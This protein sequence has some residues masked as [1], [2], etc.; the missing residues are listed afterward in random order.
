MNKKH[1]KKKSSNKKRTAVKIIAAVVILCFVWWFNNFT[2]SVHTENICDDRINSEITIVQISDLHSASFGEGNSTLIEKIKKQ[3]PDIIA[4]T[5]DMHTSNDTKGEETARNLLTKLTEIAPV[6][7]VNGEHDLKKSFSESLSECGVNVLNYKD[8]I[9]TVND[10]EL[11]LYG[12]TNVYYTPTFDL[13]N[14][15]EPDS[16]RYSIL[17]AHINKFGKFA[18]FGIDLSLCGDTHGGMFRLPFVGAVYTPDGGLFPELSGKY[19]EGMYEKN[20]KRM[21]ITSGL[22]NYPLPIRFCNRPEIAVIKLKPS[23]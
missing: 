7:Y 23:K 4:V 6:Y 18:D 14:K 3:S 22:G 20:G 5:G 8:E 19:V 17:L 11:H 12:I 9:V 10:T 15:F 16:E 13:A 21:F 2:I 1:V